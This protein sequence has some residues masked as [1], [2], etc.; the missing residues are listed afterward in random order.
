MNRNISP[1][2]KTVII[3]WVNYEEIPQCNGG[4]SKRGQQ[5]KDNLNYLKGS[6]TGSRTVDLKSFCKILHFPEEIKETLEKRE[7]P[8]HQPHTT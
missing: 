1:D 4:K 7:I 2:Q 8:V 5:Y 6:T 3:I